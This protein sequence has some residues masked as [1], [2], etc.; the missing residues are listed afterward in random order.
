L[1]PAN[2]HSEGNW[3]I[4]NNATKTTDGSKH[5]VCTVCGTTVRTEIIPATGSVGIGYTVTVYGQSCAI[6][7]L[8]S[9]SDKVVYIP[10]VIDGYTVT[11]IGDYA[12][13][14]TAITGVVIP[15]SVESIGQKAFYRCEKLTSVKIGNSVTSIGESAFYYCTNL[16]TLTF[17]DSLLFIDDYAF[18]E[19]HRLAKLTLPNGLRPIGKGAF[20]LCVDIVSVTIPDSVMSVGDSAFYRCLSLTRVTIGNGV[21]YI[22]REAFSNCEKLKSMILGSKVSSLGNEVFYD[23]A[24]STISYNGTTAQWNAISKGNGWN[25]TNTFT[26]TVYC[27]NGNVKY[28]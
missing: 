9:C 19:C 26:L 4:D 7:G 10:S 8:G 16:T 20:N 2:G 6:T 15:D 28:E 3:I 23:T 24:L 21:T 11:S 14:F 17:G 13:S 25:N 12:F 22:G 5:T 27:L 1:I 18:S